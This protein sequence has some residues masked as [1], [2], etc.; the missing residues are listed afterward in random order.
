VELASRFEIYAEQYILA[1]EVEAKLVVSMAKTGIYPTAVKYLSEL[2]STINSLKSSGIE[3]SNE[4][5][6]QIAALLASMMETVGKLGSA[7]GQHDFSTPEEHMQFC[8]KTIRPL[9]DE[10]RQ[11]A[12]ALEGEIAD[13]LWPYPTYQEMLFIK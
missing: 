6:V 4:R 12:D 1:I 9:M 7:I 11:Y 3:L 10:V 2:S 13:E 8:A 5:L